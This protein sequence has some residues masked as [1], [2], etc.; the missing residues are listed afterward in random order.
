MC[1]QALSTPCLNVSTISLKAGDEIIFNVADG[2]GDMDVS[3]C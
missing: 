2:I 1:T 3:V